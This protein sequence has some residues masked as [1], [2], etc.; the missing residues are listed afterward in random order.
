[1]ETETPNSR[2]LA[3]GDAAAFHEVLRSAVSTADGS[4]ASPGVNVA[5]SARSQIDVSAADESWR[6][7]FHLARPPYGNG[8]V[9]EAFSTAP[10]YVGLPGI[11]A[12][13]HNPMSYSSGL[14]M[15]RIFMIR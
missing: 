9:S 7:R 10:C 11:S 3:I 5:P 6:P 15:A 4:Q 13:L 14:T 8:P 12:R 1:M 2:I